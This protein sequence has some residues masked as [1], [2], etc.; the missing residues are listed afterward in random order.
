MKDHIV[1]ITATAGGFVSAL[2][3]KIPLLGV[4]ET[5]AHRLLIALLCGILSGVAGWFIKFFLDRKYEKYQD[6]KRREEWQEK[7]K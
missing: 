5:D 1:E 6:R 7:N 2:F 3:L 4:M